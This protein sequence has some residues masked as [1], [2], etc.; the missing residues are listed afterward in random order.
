MGSGSLVY[1]PGWCCQRPMVGQG[2]RGGG[3]HGLCLAGAGVSVTRKRPGQCWVFI[4]WWP[5]QE[6]SGGGFPDVGTSDHAAASGV[7]GGVH[8]VESFV[9]DVGVNRGG[10]EP[11]MAEHFL[12]DPQIGTMVEHVGGARMAEQ[13][14]TAVTTK[15]DLIEIAPD[16]VAHGAGTEPF[17]VAGEEHGLAG[18]ITTS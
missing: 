1:S 5:W 8:V 3:P 9:A 4:P 13:M 18:G 10:I 17:G 7:A 2:A 14:A 11:G 16:K 12:D 6:A 15:A